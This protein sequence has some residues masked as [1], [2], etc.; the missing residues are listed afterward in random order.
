[1]SLESLLKIVAHLAILSSLMK[2]K[3]TLWDIGYHRGLR[4]QS[5]VVCSLWVYWLFIF[6]SFNKFIDR[7]KF[8]YFIDLDIH[9]RFIEIPLSWETDCI[10]IGM[11]FVGRHS[12]CLWLRRWRYNRLSWTVPNHFSKNGQTSN[13][14]NNNSSRKWKWSQLNTIHHHQLVSLSFRVIVNQLVA[15][16]FSWCPTFAQWLHSLGGHVYVLVGYSRVDSDGDMKLLKLWV[17][18]IKIH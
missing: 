17:I 9:H 5:S 14:F 4:L 6:F 7:R 11:L 12:V 2:T 15:L 13:D 18:I 1:M 8:Y 10:F 3:E 16:F